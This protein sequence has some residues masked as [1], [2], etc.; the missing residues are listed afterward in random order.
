MAIVQISKI[1]HRTGANVDLPQLDIGELG[2]ANDDRRLYI[3]DDPVLHPPASD[4]E[5]TQT[6][7][8]TEHSQLSF[9][10][11]GGTSNTSLELNDV[12]TG[13][14]LVASGNSTVANTWVNWDGNRI[15]PDSQ[16]LILGTPG[17][18]KITGGTSGM[19]LATDGQGNLT[20]TDSIGAVTIEGTPGGTGLGEVQFNTGNDFDG[21]SA[22]KFDVVNSNLVITGNANISGNILGNVVGSHDGPVGETTPNSGAFTTIVTTSTTIIGGNLTAANISTAGNLVVTNTATIGNISSSGETSVTDLIV[23]GNVS[24]S[25]IPEPDATYDLGDADSRWTNA[26]ISSA[27]YLGERVIYAEDSNVVISGNLSVDNAVLGNS[28]TANFFT[29][30]L[31]TG[32]Q[33]NISSVGNLEALRVTG[34]INVSNVANIIIPGG[35]NNFVLGTNGFG[36][37]RWVP[38][39]ELLRK[40]SGSNT[41]VQFNDGGDFGAVAGFAFDKSSNTVG[42]G[43][44]LLTGNVQAQANITGQNITSNANLNGNIITAGTRFTGNATGLTNIPGANVTGT[45]PNATTATF[46]GTVTTGAQPNITGVGTLSSLSVSGTVAAGNITVVNNLTSDKIQSSTVLGNIVPD[47]GINQSL[48]TSI[49]RWK[50]VFV[51]GN[52]HVGDSVVKD[53]TGT[54][55]TDNMRVSNSMIVGSSTESTQLDVMKI[56]S[57]INSLY[58]STDASGISATTGPEQAGVGIYLNDSDNEVTSRVYTVAGSTDI[59]KVTSDGIVPADIDIYSLGTDALRWSNVVAQTAK[60]E[61]VNLGSFEM[62]SNIDGIFFR[63]T[64][65]DDVFSVALNLVV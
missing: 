43:S 34:V 21:V 46:A 44:I 55:V 51:S 52:I 60:V 59:S 57:S 25:L 35:S 39:T 22:F 45:V 16:K 29:G 23:N 9:N 10:K 61:K 15:G 7:I 32:A 64:A 42:V 38:N 3:G 20:W 30:T 8:L 1:I 65:T 5:T 12:M 54:L 41:F 2:Y 17:N 36:N 24:S 14:L 13:Q 53:E 58:I 18:I 28:A 56:A 47:S 26:Y 62:F 48:G 33:P 4:G 27:V 19:F 11:I 50:D 63:N 6:E 37:L 31:T 40:P 49:K